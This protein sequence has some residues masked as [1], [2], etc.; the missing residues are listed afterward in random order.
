LNRWDERLRLAKVFRNCTV[1][2]AL[3]AHKT[4]QFGFL[5]AFEEL[6]ENINT[7]AEGTFSY[8]SL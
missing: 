7:F 1:H 3:S 4:Q 8:L 6:V 2:G 5:T